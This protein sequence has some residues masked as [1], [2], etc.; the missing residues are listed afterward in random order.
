MHILNYQYMY[1]LLILECVRQFDP[2]PLGHAKQYRVSFIL[3]FYHN[4]RL[5]DWLPYSRMM[6]MKSVG[7]FINVYNE[8]W[9]FY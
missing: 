3:T 2:D 4:C 5:S 6:S 9:L 7:I 8:R 1:I